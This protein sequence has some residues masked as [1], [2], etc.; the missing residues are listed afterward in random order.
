[1]EAY[2]H[3]HGAITGDSSVILFRVGLVEY[4]ISRYASVSDF[5]AKCYQKI[6]LK[7]KTRIGGPNEEPQYKFLW[8][9]MEN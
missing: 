5:I 9:N 2:S 7:K 4:T 3:C 1:M 8:R 6:C